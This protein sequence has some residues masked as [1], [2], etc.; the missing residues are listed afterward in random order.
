V[1]RS[2]KPWTLVARFKAFPFKAA[3]LWLT[4]SLVPIMIGMAVA[5]ALDSALLGLIGACLILLLAVAIWAAIAPGA[6]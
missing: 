4:G 3:G 6:R 1:A 5:T 2:G